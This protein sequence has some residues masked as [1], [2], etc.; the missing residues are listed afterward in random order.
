MSALIGKSRAFGQVFEAIAV[1]A[2][3]DSA[4]LF[5]GETGTGKTLIARAIHDTLGPWLLPLPVRR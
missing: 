5:I 3:V 1:V 4:V 2:P